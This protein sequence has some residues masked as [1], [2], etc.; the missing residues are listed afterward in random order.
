MTTNID[1][2]TYYDGDPKEGAEPCG[3]PCQG[4]SSYCAEHHAKVYVKS[5][6]FNLR[7]Q[8]GGR[9]SE[10]EPASR[11]RNVD[12][13]ALSSNISRGKARAVVSEEHGG[14]H[15]LERGGRRPV[16]NEE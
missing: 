7:S 1:G 6:P 14:K 12:A 4:K 16:D 5:K 3:K 13:W 11:V 10:G 9:Y 8:R 2:C 15:I